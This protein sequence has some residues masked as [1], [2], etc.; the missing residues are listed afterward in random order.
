MHALLRHNYYYI[1]IYM[2]WLKVI[3]LEALP[4]V[5]IV[6]LNTLIIKKESNRSRAS[7]TLCISPVLCRALLIISIYPFLPSWKGQIEFLD[8]RP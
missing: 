2:F 8:F 5:F 1:T 7:Q 6:V 3:F 4:Y